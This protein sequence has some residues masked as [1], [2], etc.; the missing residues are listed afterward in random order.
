MLKKITTPFIHPIRELAESG[1]LGGVLLIIATLFSIIVTNSK[2]GEA[3][4]HFWHIN[5]GNS[6]L[7]M[8]LAHWIN[9]ALMAIFF[10]LVGL[11]IKRE[12]VS[13][14][15]SSPKK[16]MLPLL[17]AIGGMIFPA[18]IYFLFNHNTHNAHG[19]AI[20]TATDIA[21]SLGVLSLLGKRV[22]LSLKIFLTALAIIDDL[23]GI[24]IIAVFY[25]AEIHFTYLLYAGI[26]LFVLFLLNTF[27]VRKFI[28][29]FIPALCLWYCV[30][31]S[32]VHATIAGVLSALF[33]PIEKIEKY[34]HYLHQPV[35]YLI[36]P[37]FALVNTTILLSADSIV[38]VSSPL[39]L[40]IILALFLGK[41]FGITL[42][43]YISIKTKTGEL[44]DNSDIKDI[45]GVSML[46]GIG[47]TMSL[48]FTALSF[49]NPESANIARLSIIIGSTL[50]AV[51]G[52]LFLSFTLD[53]E[54]MN[55]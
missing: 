29:Y 24:I 45:F 30:Y 55:Q 52:L 33:I 50:S 28:F 21:F 37:I 43:T 11:E 53:K 18:L 25:T 12:I 1:K 10:F 7:S 42:F 19:W 48:F 26:I 2:Y 47:F 51:C 16:A 35:N 20:P 6:F 32:G 41:S 4:L 36:L 23:G 5:L 38:H 3:Y 13:G 44:Q 49:D 9:D 39:G 40:G 15:L 22:P 54:A 31:Q 17:A 34:E 46:A 14:E 27:K 8:H